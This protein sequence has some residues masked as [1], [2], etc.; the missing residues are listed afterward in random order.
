MSEPTQ[1]Q[2]LQES[3]V[4][5]KARLFDVQEQASAVKAQADEYAGALSEIAQAVGITGES[6]TL[7]DIIKAVKALVP[8]QGELE[9]EP[10]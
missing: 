8:E 4:L 2:K 10:E 6:V 3:V 1:E 5:L 9:V 7:V